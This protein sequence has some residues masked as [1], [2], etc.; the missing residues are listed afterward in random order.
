MK[1]IIA[2]LCKSNFSLCVNV[3]APSSQYQKINPLPRPSPAKK[4]AATTQQKKPMQ[5]SPDG[6]FN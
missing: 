1:I 5:I 3:H 2:T 6:Y 4:V